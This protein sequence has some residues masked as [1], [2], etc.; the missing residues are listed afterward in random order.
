MSGAHDTTSDDTAS[1][2]TASDDTLGHD[3][4]GQRIL[5]ALDGLL[6]ALELEPL[7]D[8][9]FRVVNEPGRFDRIFGG[10]TVAQALLGR[11][12]PSAGRPRTRSTHTSCE[13]ARPTSRSRCGSSA[14]GTVG[15]CRR[16]APACGK[17]NA[18]C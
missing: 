10:Q 6:D 5:V 3:A 17:A 11:A 1:D 8:D 2:D 14:C 18:S 4:L 16:V 13:V 12:R 7:G 15:R 9:R